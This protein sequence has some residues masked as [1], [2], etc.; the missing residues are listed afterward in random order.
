VNWRADRMVISNFEVRRLTPGEIELAKELW[1]DSEFI[2]TDEFW[3]ADFEVDG[4]KR[5]AG[6]KWG[7]SVD[8]A[9][10][11]QQFNVQLRINQEELDEDIPLIPEAQVADIVKAVSEEFEKG[12]YWNCP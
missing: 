11:M 3:I 2:P 5:Q 1:A 4:M 8:V 10:D 7:R 12:E 6:I 9:A